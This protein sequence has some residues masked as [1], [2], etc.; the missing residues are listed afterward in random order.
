MPTPFDRRLARHARSTAPYLLACVLLG[1]LGAGCVLAQAAL[2]AHAVAAPAFPAA[3]AAVIALRALLVWGQEVVAH[4]AAAGVTSQLRAGLLAR[5][6]ADRPGARSG[7]LTA[8]VTRGVDALDPYF[9]RYLPQLVLALLVPVTVLAA[10]AAADPAAAAIVAATLPLIPVFGVLIGTYA[11]SRTRRQWRT[12]EVLAGHFADVVAGLPALKAFGRARAQA[13]HI[14][15]VTG[16][17]RRATLATLRIAFCSALVLELAATLAVALVAVSVG[18]RLV[19]GSISFETAL[20]VLIL[21]PEAYL[22]LRQAAAQFHAGQE[23]LA[24]ADRIL[25]LLDEPVPAPR[26]VSSPSRGDLRVEALAPREA[27]GPFSLDVPE[28]AI[29]A[30]TGPSGAGKSSLIGALAGLVTPVSGRILS[31]GVQVVADDAW[32]RGIAWVPQRPFLFEGTVAENIA[33]AVP[34]APG[35]AVSRAAEAVGVC[36]FT[37]LDT[38]L[39]VGGEGLS[40][41]QRHRVALARAALRCDLLDTWL[42]LLDE[43]TAHLDVLTEVAVAEALTDLLRGR[44]AL[45]ATHRRALLERAD[46]V[47][48]LSVRRDAELGSEPDRAV[49]V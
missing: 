18:L 15:R 11:A 35:T 5:V 38:R 24:A 30:L 31:G 3:L 16:D 23:G 22:P 37:T 40:A 27:V 7:E 8:L 9:S 26:P 12:L 48:E 20:F 34:E 42:V 25:G 44:T 2:L 13:R 41:G 45:V 32:R 29:T 10:L 1:A 47:V 49:T 14:E 46:R 19:G 36:T 17:H 33:I 21:A 43:P 28:R 39:G 6:T 4:R